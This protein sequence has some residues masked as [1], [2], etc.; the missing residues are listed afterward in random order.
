[1]VNEELKESMCGL[2]FEKLQEIIDLSCLN[3]SLYDYK[4]TNDYKKICQ[5]V[6]QYQDKYQR[7]L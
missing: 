7:E 6:K 4:K 2:V 5:I 1:M 3:S